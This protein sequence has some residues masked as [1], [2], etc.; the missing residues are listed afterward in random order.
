VAFVK[1]NFAMKEN[2]ITLRVITLNDIGAAIRLSN[3]EK[4]NQTEADWRLLV[5]NPLNICLLAECNNKVIGTST[6]INY[7]NEVAWVAMVLVDKD[8][9]GMG[10]SRLLLTEM[11]RRTECC[12]IVKLDATPSG[13]QVYRDFGFEI[14][15][16]INRMENRCLIKLTLDDYD[17]LPEPVQLTDMQEIISFDKIVFGVKRSQLI[18]HLIRNFPQK[19]WKLKRNNRLTG[20]ALGRDG[21]IFHHIGPVMAESSTDAK[22]LITKSFNELIEKSVIIDVLNDKEDLIE[23]LDSSG[24]TQQRQFFRMYKRENPYPGVTVNQY[25]ICGPEF[26]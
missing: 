14:E 3:A 7:S 2:P 23:W 1:N 13:Q 19:A 12:R 8:Y 18:E 4:W 9:R 15:Y 25:S 26:G 17:I 5:E 22:I 20:F 16:G 21:S 6:A 10:V 24:F 11:F